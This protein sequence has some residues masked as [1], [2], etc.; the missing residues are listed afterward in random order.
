VALAVVLVLGDA[1]VVTRRGDGPL[2]AVLGSGP[3]GPATPTAATADDEGPPPELLGN[4]TPVRQ[5]PEQNGGRTKQKEVA[6][7]LDWT[8][9]E[10]S[11]VVGDLGNEGE[12][13]SL[14]LGRE[15][16]FALPDV[17]IDGTESDGDA[18]PGCTRHL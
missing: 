7:Q 9:A 2:P 3:G 15:N 17:D 12:G 10:T 4:E 18:Q 11:Q 16:V 6:E 8:A 13:E 14:R 1:R 5:L